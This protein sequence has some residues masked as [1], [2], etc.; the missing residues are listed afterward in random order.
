MQD[1]LIL[2][3]STDIMRL[4]GCYPEEIA[5]Q[6]DLLSFSIKTARSALDVF[7]DQKFEEPLYCY[8]NA[9]ILGDE[10]GWYCETLLHQ[11]LP[12]SDSEGWIAHGEYSRRIEPEAEIQGEYTGFIVFTANAE[13]HALHYQRM[14]ARWASQSICKSAEEANQHLDTIT[15]FLS[16]LPRGTTVHQE[17]ALGRLRT[18]AT[19]ILRAIAIMERAAN[20]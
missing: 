6:D 16:L 15:N 14:H 19:D 5:A 13:D 9:E 11:Q 8:I 17:K 4:T 1:D 10:E 3:R 7:G 20:G 12:T 18:R 2:S